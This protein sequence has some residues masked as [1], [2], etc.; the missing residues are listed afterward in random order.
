M[1]RKKNTPAVRSKILSKLIFAS[2]VI[3]PSRVLLAVSGRQLYI[4]A[5]A[6]IGIERHRLVRRAICFLFQQKQC[7]HVSFINDYTAMSSMGK[8]TD[9]VVTMSSSEQQCCGTLNPTN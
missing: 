5:A 4:A 8:V 3:L 1:K 9:S 6:E 7:G 2:C